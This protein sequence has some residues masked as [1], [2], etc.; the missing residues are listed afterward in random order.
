[1]KKQTTTQNMNN[2]KYEVSWDGPSG[3]LQLAW[4][5]KPYMI[6]L[7]WTKSQGRVPL[8]WSWFYVGHLLH[9]WDSL[10]YFSRNNHT[11]RIKCIL[12]YS[13]VEIEPSTTEYIFTF[14]PMKTCW[15]SSFTTAGHQHFI[16]LKWVREH[17]QGA[18]PGQL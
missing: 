18:W 11:K 15:S 12:S 8:Q 3:G 13:G 4:V 10:F 14:S 9:I 17:L 16:V 2:R 6:G 1:M 5:L 7:Y